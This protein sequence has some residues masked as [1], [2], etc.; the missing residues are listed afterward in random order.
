M[1]SD[2]EFSRTIRRLKNVALFAYLSDDALGELAEKVEMRDFAKDEALF[3]KDDA[4]DSLFV[5]RSG[6]AKIVTEEADGSELIISHVGPGQAIGDMSLLDG[7]PYLVSVVALVPVRT[8]VVKRAVF[9]E[10]LNKHPLY[11]LEVI[12]G[13]A[14]KMRLNITY[15]RKAIDWSNKIAQGDYTSPIEQ[16]NTEHTS[17]TTRAKP[18]EALVAE[19]LASFHTMVHGVKT[20]EE[21]LIKHIQELAIKIDSS[22][23]DEEVDQLTQSTF[24]KNLKEARDRLRR[25]KEE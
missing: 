14:E 25:P 13:L 22:K 3:C 21:T 16:I 4:V 23:V 2:V 12:R 15:V 6:W 5:F 24:F 10:W 11:A 7:Q 1:E 9:L 8:M 19:F 17:V 20:R 18:D